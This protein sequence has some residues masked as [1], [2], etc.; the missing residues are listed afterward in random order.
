MVRDKGAL[1][2]LELAP[3]TPQATVTPVHP[4]GRCRPRHFKAPPC[5]MGRSTRPDAK[6][7]KAA[8]TMG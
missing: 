6:I 3:D 2:R 5:P 8:E 7:K 1:E 4:S